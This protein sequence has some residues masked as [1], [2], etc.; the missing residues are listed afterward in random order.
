[1]SSPTLATT[2]ALFDFLD[3]SKV[4]VTFLTLL[5]SPPLLLLHSWNPQVYEIWILL[6]FSSISDIPDT[7]ESLIF[8]EESLAPLTS[9]TF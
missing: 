5:L 6:G 2:T 3:E 1:M 4:S 7:S 8:L 9:L